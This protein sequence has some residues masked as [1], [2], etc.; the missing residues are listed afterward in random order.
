MASV[1]IVHIPGFTHPVREFFLESALQLAGIT[2]GPVGSE[3][4][5]CYSMTDALILRLASL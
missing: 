2:A 1:P 5:V 4:F 3:R